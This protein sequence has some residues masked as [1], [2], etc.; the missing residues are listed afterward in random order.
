MASMVN[1]NP[2]TSP[3]THTSVSSTPIHPS[4]PAMSNP[5]ARPMAAAAIV[6]AAE[7]RWIP[8]NRRPSQAKMR[9]MITATTNQRIHCIRRC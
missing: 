7:N 3:T 1:N 8:S 5:E 4:A 2:K 6:L 9:K